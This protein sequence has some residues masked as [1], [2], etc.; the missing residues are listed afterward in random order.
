MSVS[1]DLQLG[2][3]Q[4][5]HQV[6]SGARDVHLSA[7][8]LLVHEVK[9]SAF[10]FGYFRRVLSWIW[11]CW[12]VFP[13]SK[14]KKKKCEISKTE[15]NEVTEDMR[16]TFLSDEGWQLFGALIFSVTCELILLVLSIRCRLVLTC[17]CCTA[18]FSLVTHEPFNPSSRVCGV[19]TRLKDLA[20]VLVQKRPQTTRFFLTG[21]RSPEPEDLH[22]ATVVVGP[23]A[24]KHQSTLFIRNTVVCF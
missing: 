7:S 3:G 8:P 20:V 14:K 11:S 9:P 19:Q 16:T 2:T 5:P 1:G 4:Q 17:S 13:G 10:L 18:R 6:V 15:P 22:R 21:P 24:A 23:D 12:F